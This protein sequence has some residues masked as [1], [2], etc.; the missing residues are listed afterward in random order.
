M[1]VFLAGSTDLALLALVGSFALGFA[2]FAYLAALT[3][4]SDLMIWSLVWSESLTMAGF[5]DFICATFDLD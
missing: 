4:L 2:T 5:L 3:F 1:T